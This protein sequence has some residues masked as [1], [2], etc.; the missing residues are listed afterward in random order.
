VD[1]AELE[2]VLAILRAGRSDAD[3]PPLLKPLDSAYDAAALALY[4]AYAPQLVREL[5]R[6]RVDPALCTPTRTRAT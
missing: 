4:R 6:L 5:R 2:R 1:R 3:G